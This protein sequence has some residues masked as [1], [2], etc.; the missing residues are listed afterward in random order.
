MKYAI[1]RAPHPNARY[2]AKLDKLTL[3]ELTALLESM[4]LHTSLTLE[5]IGG[6]PLYTFESERPAA[7][8]NALY[9]CSSLMCVFE[10]QGNALVPLMEGY[11]TP[12]FYDMPSILKY[13][14][15]TNESFTRLLINLAVSASGFRFDQR[16][17]I[18][19]PLCGKGTT[20]F[21]ALGLGFDAI[22][23][24]LDKK[25]VKEA[26]DFVKAYLRNG[27]FKHSFEKSSVTANG[28]EAGELYTFTT[29]KTAEDFKENK[30]QRLSIAC[31]NAAKTEAFYKKKPAHILVAD[32]P[33]GVLHANDKTKK[34]S[35]TLQMVTRLLP[36][37]REE[38]LPTGALALSFNSYTLKRDDLRDAL[39]SAG[40]EP[41]CGGWADELE[42]WV[43]QAV[44]RD[45]VIAVKPARQP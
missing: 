34:G 5:K 45:A 7:E 22:G 17:T 6:L 44:M 36:A 4:Q 16:L 35:D 1:L 8:L 21:C 28:K 19:D 41:V 20:L 14:G 3:C 26:V 38:L 10:V 43:E 25:E 33:Y 37:F 40:F 9:R 32:L 27:R 2:D 23:I 24:E 31:G 11:E 29:A 30:T 42:H 12:A 13:K 39:R 18:F 15:K